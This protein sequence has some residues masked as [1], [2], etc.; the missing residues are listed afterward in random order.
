MQRVCESKFQS[1]L[2]S[3]R[4]EGQRAEDRGTAKEKMREGGGQAERL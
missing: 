2:S 3:L 1:F 4:Q